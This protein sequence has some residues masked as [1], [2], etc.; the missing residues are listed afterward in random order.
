MDQ[1]K[2]V[3]T[4]LSILSWVSTIFAQDPDTLWTKTYDG[5]NFDTGWS[6]QETSDSGFIVVGEATSI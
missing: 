6:V 1:M 2:R 4:I 3:I 5:P